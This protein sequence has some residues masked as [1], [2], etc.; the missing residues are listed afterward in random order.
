VL[1]LLVAPLLCPASARAESKSALSWVRESGAEQCIGAVELG[2]R[3]ERLVGPM[4]VAAP[5]GQ[6]SVE[7][8]IARVKSGF[9]AQIVVSD[10]QGAVLGTR[11]LDSPGD[12]CRAID[13]KLVFVI[14]VAID[15]NAALASLPGELS[16]E[17]AAGTDLLADLRAQP[18]RP[19]A[20]AAPMAPAKP[21]PRAAGNQPT[22]APPSDAFRFSAAIELSLGLGALMKPSV[23]GRPSVAL[24]RE[25]LAFW[26]HF[27]AWL[28]Q[29][30][31]VRGDQGVQVDSYGLGLGVCPLRLG[32]HPWSL[33]LCAG[34]GADELLA[35]PKNFTGEKQVRVQAGPE[36]E[37]RAVAEVTRH[38]WLGLSATAQNRWPRHELGYQFAEQF[39]RVY[40][41]PLLS[42]RL[43]AELELRF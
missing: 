11:E 20:A 2:Q 27:S 26:L 3:V 34:V 25:D 30:Q 7:G 35:R 38:L 9:A 14:A 43:S 41:T 36:L 31:R 18:P 37:L 10:A 32:A 17:D 22:P 40:R 42:G 1:L 16:Q 13:D 19:A 33:W 21:S 29:T 23:G 8:R 5:A 4:L 39:M 15:P 6:V 28:R 24:T 12:D